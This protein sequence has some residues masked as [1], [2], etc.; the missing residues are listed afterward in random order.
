M[1]KVLEQKVRDG[2]V[3]VASMRGACAP[4]ELPL[5]LAQQRD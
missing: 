1:S 4:P 5:A 3:A 2:E